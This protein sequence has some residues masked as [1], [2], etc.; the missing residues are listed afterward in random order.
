MSISVSVVSLKAVNAAWGLLDGTHKWLCSA[1]GILAVA[2]LWEHNTPLQLL[3]RWNVQVE[4]VVPYVSTDSWQRG[5]V[6][7][8]AVIAVLAMIGLV[9]VGRDQSWTFSHIDVYGPDGY[10]KYREDQRLYVER[11]LRNLGWMWLAVLLFTQ[12]GTFT[13]DRMWLFVAGVCFV[14][15]IAE[16][17]DSG[18][19]SHDRRELFLVR[20]LAVIPFGCLALVMLPLRLFGL[21]SYPRSHRRG[22]AEVIPLPKEEQAQSVAFREGL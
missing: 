22:P 11:D 19:T 5:L 8:G 13:P 6:I 16:T 7:G 10:D 3:G 12:T 15:G 2:S 20:S 4:P 1:A 14:R 17:S 18:N 21:F 9:A